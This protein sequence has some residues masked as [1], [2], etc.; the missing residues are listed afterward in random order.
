MVEK[1]VFPKLPNRSALWWRE[2]E[3]GQ[4]PPVMLQALEA[5]GILPLADDPAWALPV[6]LRFGP[7]N[8]SGMSL[9]T[10]LAP[11]KNGE[12]VDR[13]LSSILNEIIKYWSNREAI[14]GEAQVI[15]RR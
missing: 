11:I 5:M 13:G 14:R 12:D 6:L 7:S 3:S 2:V 15:G 9:H 4:L 8:C 1:E 10:W